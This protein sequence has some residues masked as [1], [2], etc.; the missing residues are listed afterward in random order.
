MHCWYYHHGG[1]KF[2]GCRYAHEDIPQEEIDRIPTPRREMSPP[3]EGGQVPDGP[4]P[5]YR[6]AADD[7]KGVG[8]LAPSRVTSKK[9]CFEYISGATCRPG[10]S[11]PYRHVTAVQYQSIKDAK[12]ASSRARGSAGVCLFRGIITGDGSREPNDPR[13]PIAAHQRRPSI[14]A[15]SG[16]SFAFGAPHWPWSLGLRGGFPRDRGSDWFGP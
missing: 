2:Q 6:P 9:M 5:P 15:A 11:C 4:R 12:R 1:C 10:E 8:T 7:G 14:M 13:E 3:R 16:D